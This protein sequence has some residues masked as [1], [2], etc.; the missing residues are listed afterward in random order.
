[1]DRGR[2][3][4]LSHREI[5]SDYC[6]W[7][8]GNT[9]VGDTEIDEESKIISILW[10]A[11]EFFKESLLKYGSKDILMRVLFPIFLQTPNTRMP[12]ISNLTIIPTDPVCW[13]LWGLGAE[14]EMF[15]I[16]FLLLQSLHCVVLEWGICIYLLINSFSNTFPRTFQAQFLKVANMV[17]ETQLLASKKLTEND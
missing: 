2:T 7:Q 6:C 5:V 10:S 4:P 14:M 15:V 3:H 17:N 16:I 12:C 13:T 8:D 9:V 1:M 11:W